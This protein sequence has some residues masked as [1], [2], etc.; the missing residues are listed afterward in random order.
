MSA[1]NKQIYYKYIQNAIQMENGIILIHTNF[2]DAKEKLRQIKK[3]LVEK[4][5]GIK[6]HNV[7]LTVQDALN[8]RKLSNKGVSVKLLSQKFNVKQSHIRKIIKRQRWKHI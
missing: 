1:G 3:I 4:K 7:K 2:S 6:Y 5:T 8:I